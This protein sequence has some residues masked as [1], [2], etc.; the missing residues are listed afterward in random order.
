[1]RAVLDAARAVFAEEREL[2]VPSLHRSFTIRIN[3]STR[4]RS[5][6]DAWP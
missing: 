6:H 5:R 1:V 2:D 3:E 4:R